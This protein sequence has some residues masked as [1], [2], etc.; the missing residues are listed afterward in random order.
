MLIEKLDGRPSNT[1]WECD[2]CKLH[3]EMLS[4]RVS[5]GKHHFCSKECKKKWDKTESVKRLHNW[6]KKNGSPNYKSGTGITTDGYVWIYVKGR[7]H[8]QI[9]LHRYLMGKKIGRKLK[10]SEI[11]HH[12]NFDKL[13]N[14]IGNLQIVTRSE[15]NKIHNSLKNRKGL[16]TDKE[17]N[18]ILKNK[19]KSIKYKFP[20]K[21]INSLYS[22][23]CRLKK[24][25]L[26]KTKQK[27]KGDMR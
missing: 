1:I 24:A 26:E 21:T 25:N 22:Q 3:F 6:I 2:H 23:K 15:H 10:F 20:D 19:I 5:G 14:R 12:I 27:G 9:K 17:N 18:L 13:D 16:Y 7:P 8:N 4:R 11:V